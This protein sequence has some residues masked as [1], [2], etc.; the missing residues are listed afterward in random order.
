MIINKSNTYSTAYLL[1]LLNSSLMQAFWLANFYD[2]R[3]TFPKIKGSYLKD[4]PIRTIDFDDPADTARHDRMVAL[5]EQMLDLHQR[6]AAAA[7]PADRTL[8]QRQIET[9]DV[10]IDA[11][12]YELYGLTEEE[13]AIVEGAAGS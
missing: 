9:T 13:I 7:I 3:V 1:G 6:R 2:Q 12:V 4:L 8:I 5:V 10:A 11:L